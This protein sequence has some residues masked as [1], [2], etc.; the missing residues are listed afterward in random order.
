MVCEEDFNMFDTLMNRCNENIDV[1]ED[2]TTKCKH[3]N[4]VHENNSV[5]CPDCGETIKKITHDQEWRFYGSSDSKRRTDPTRVQERKIHERNINKDIENMGFSKNII[6]KANEI[7]TKVTNGQIYRG[8]S[9]KSIIFACVYHAYK[10][11]SSLQ[12]PTNLVQIFNI[13]KKSSLRGMKIVKINMYMDLPVQNTMMTIENHIDDTMN[14]FSATKEQKNEVYELYN[15]IKNRSSKLNRSRPQSVSISLIYYWILKNKKPI[16][17]KQ[18]SSQ[19][20]LSEMTI[21]KNITE[22][23]NILNK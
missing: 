1:K 2:N 22:I 18:Y 15:S 21:N 19:V 4:N 20:G 16:S 8:D 5:F 11:D 14:Y 7:Y 13:S 9:R 3:V 10:L 12:I 17:L 23:K 6:E